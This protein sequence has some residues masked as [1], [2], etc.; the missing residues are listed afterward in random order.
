MRTSGLVVCDI[1]NCLQ[2]LAEHPLTD[3]LSQLVSTLIFAPGVKEVSAGYVA[4]FLQ[5]LLSDEI[6][7]YLKCIMLQNLVSLRCREPKYRSRP[8]TSVELE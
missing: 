6:Q 3:S 8:L 5:I 7:Q 4:E 1:F 2:Q